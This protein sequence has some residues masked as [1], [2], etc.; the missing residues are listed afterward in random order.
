LQAWGD[1]NQVDPLEQYFANEALPRYGCSGNWWSAMAEMTAAPEDV[2]LYPLRGLRGMAQMMNI[3]L[4]FWWM[5]ESWYSRTN[6]V[7]TDFF[8]GSNIIE[9]AVHVNKEGGVCP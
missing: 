8:L 9:M 3:P 5:R 6:I 1:K 4:T 2:I 7:S